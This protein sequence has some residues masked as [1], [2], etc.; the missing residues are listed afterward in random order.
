M[1]IYTG[2][3]LS[4]DDARGDGLEVD[5]KGVDFGFGGEVL[6]CRHFL[7]ETVTEGLV[8]VYPPREGA[9]EG[10]WGDFFQLR[11]CK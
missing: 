3:F 4:A 1:F 7:G 9:G 6:G 11:G 2:E 5:V 10:R 8:A